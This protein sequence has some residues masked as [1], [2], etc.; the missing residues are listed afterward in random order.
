MPDPVVIE[1]RPPEALLT[2]CPQPEYVEPKTNK[3]LTELLID[4]SEC[5]HICTMQMQSLIKF[6][7][8]NHGDR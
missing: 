3:E 6:Y 5:L 8:G 2:P 4:T 7:R 1:I